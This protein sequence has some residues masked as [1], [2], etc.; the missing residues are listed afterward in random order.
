MCRIFATTLVLALGIAAPL[1]AQTAAVPK[2][3]VDKD[4][5]HRVYRLTD[6]PGSSAFYFNVNAYSPD[7]RFMV[8]TAP[9]GIHT[10]EMATRRTRLLVPNPP[11]PANAEP[12]TGA[13]TT[14]IARSSSA[15]RH[16]ASSSR[17]S[18]R[19]RISPSSTRPTWSPAR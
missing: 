16:P 7:G 13:G 18:I 8:Y 17:A 19:T 14:A 1:A 15:T 11:P 2:T 10:F 4:T 9:D 5:G 6:E 12:K 3:W